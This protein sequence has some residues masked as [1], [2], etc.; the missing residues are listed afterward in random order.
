MV[1]YAVREDYDCVESIM[2]QVQ[3]MHVD[4]RPDI[5]KNTDV[6]L[7]EEEF[8]ELVENSM[9]VV[10]VERETVVGVMLLLCRYV[11]SNT[12]VKRKI[13]FI[14]SMAVDKNY[15]GQGIG[16]QFFDFAKKIVKQDDYDG[17]ELQVNAKN[18]AAMEMYKHYGFTEKS[19]NMEL[20]ENN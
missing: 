1:R 19:I 20:L 3:S 7:R 2:K 12:Q 4:W 14:D 9:A 5:Y 10:A 16:H 8:Y 13:L 11:Q 15:R 17:L 18:I 6:V